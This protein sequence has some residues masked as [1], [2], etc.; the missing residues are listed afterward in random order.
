MGG[1]LKARDEIT[2]NTIQKAWEETV[3][4]NR[5]CHCQAWDEIREE[6]GRRAGHRLTTQERRDRKNSLLF[7]YTHGELLKLHS[8]P[9]RV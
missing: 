8:P 4:G 1:R 5:R 2:G 9:H 7:L 6:L 3:C